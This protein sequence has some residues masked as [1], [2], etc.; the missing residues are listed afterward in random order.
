MTDKT[1]TYPEFV[2]DENFRFVGFFSDPK[3]ADQMSA[4]VNGTIFDTSQVSGMKTGDLTRLYN[5][6]VD[7]DHQVKKFSTK[8]VAIERVKKLLDDPELTKRLKDQA[9]ANTKAK[10]AAAKKEGME[11]RKRK[12]TLIPQPNK[13]WQQSV[14]YQCFCALQE[15]M[16]VE[17]YLAATEALGISEK[18]ALGCLNKMM[19]HVTQPVVAWADE[20][21]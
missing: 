9:R 3:A 13:R 21:K 2:V 8:N 15:G 6:L 5:S 16:T 1:E 14:R 19:T 11:S 4:K 12:L 17:E 18:L 20:S 7:E 10:N